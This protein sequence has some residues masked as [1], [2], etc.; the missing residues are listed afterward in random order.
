MEQAPDWRS[1]TPDAALSTLERPGFALEFLLRSAV[2]R[3][4]YA[5][6]SRRIAAG[7]VAADEA[8]A[9]LAQRWGLSF[10]G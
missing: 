9:Q 4:D 3:R 7:A 6:L 5:R 1:Q 10:P 2:Y 8:T